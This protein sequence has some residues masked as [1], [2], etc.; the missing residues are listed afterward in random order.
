PGP[1]KENF[2]K[3]DYIHY[4]LKNKILNTVDTAYTGRGGV[5]EVVDKSRDFL[6]NVRFYEERRVVQEFLGHIGQETGLATYGEREVI[7]ALRSNNVRTLLLSAG[8]RR[9]FVK[10]KCKGCGS[11]ETKIVDIDEL[12]AFEESLADTRCPDCDGTYELTEKE[13]LI[14]ALV[15][16][17]EEAGAN[18]EVISTGTEDGEMLLKS[19][20][21]IAAILRY[22]QFP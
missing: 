22:R 17:A 20:G 5:K 14:E 2:L 18:I 8:V 13:D 4:E 11:K 19:F 21:G 12:E 3:G 16:M 1:T 10:L 9:A 7:Q 15:R 6:K